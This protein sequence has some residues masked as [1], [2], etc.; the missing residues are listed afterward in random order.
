M[1]YLGRTT[2]E[3]LA[4]AL[5]LAALLVL[6]SAGPLVAEDGAG[7][8]DPTTPAAAESA[9]ALPADADASAERALSI[10]ERS[11]RYLSGLKMFALSVRSEV[12]VVQED[13]VSIEFGATRQITVRRP[14]RV[15]VVIQTRDGHER[16]LYFDGSL[17]TMYTPGDDLY[18]V[19]EAVG[20]LDDAIEAVT[21]ELGQPLPLAELLRQD[22]YGSVRDL[23]R[24]ASYVARE[25]LDDT[26]CDHLAFA[27]VD[28]DWQ[29]WV[30]RGERPLPRR[31]VIS[32]KKEDGS[33]QFRADLGGWDVD[34]DVSDEV[35][36]F[37]PPAGAE[38]IE[39][40][41]LG[42]P[43]PAMGQGR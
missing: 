19:V 43:G 21:D 10:L 16:R 1:G 30:A 13:G 9:A 24:S 12:D 2:C 25:S 42:T 37:E 23:I 8:R 33:P 4:S 18:A 38:Q 28:A 29:I 32:Y 34:P 26:D 11:S 40:A 17:V 5:A 41:P 14:D 39:F 3:H 20:T 6:A 27:G 31:L 7:P 36:T 15:R 22:F 35:F